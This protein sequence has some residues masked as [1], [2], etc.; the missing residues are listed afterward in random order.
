MIW[1]PSNPVMNA[2]QFFSLAILSLLLEN[3]SEFQF[4]A[5]L[6]SQPLLI[7]FSFL[8]PSIAFMVMFSVA[9]PSRLYWSLSCGVN[10]NGSAYWLFQDVHFNA[11]LFLNLSIILVRGHLQAANLS[12]A[13]ILIVIHPS[14][15]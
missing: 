9:N 15:S 14:G 2:F 12:L 13:L 6:L 1:Q 11:F 3:S 7:P 4:S 8:T 5:L 10:W